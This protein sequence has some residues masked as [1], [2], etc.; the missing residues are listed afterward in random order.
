MRRDETLSVVRENWPDLARHGVRSLAVFG[1]TA[2][3]EARPD[4]DVD[5]LVNFAPP[6]GLFEFVRVQMLLENLLGRTVD[7]VTVDAL[8]PTMRAQILAEAVYATQGAGRTAYPEGDRRRS[9]AC[10]P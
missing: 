3:D 6:V 9:T 10:T 2:R 7:L 8:R 5:I 4:S 1:S